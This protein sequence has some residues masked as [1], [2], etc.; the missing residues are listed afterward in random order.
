MNGF[1]LRRHGRA[2][3]QAEP[4]RTWFRCTRATVLED[5]EFTNNRIPVS[6]VYKQYISAATQSLASSNASDM[7]RAVETDK[8]RAD[9]AMRRAIKDFLD[10]PVVRAAFGEFKTK[11]DLPDFPVFLE[12]ELIHALQS[13]AETFHGLR[14]HPRVSWD[15]AVEAMDDQLKQ[16]V[17]EY[18]VRIEIWRCEGV[19]H[20][21]PWTFGTPSA[22]YHFLASTLVQLWYMDRE[23][24]FSFRSVRTS[25][26]DWDILWDSWA[27][28]G[29]TI[30]AADD[31]CVGVGRRRVGW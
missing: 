4:L 21:K 2:D 13:L 28:E 25:S 17:L 19:A 27:E 7:R 10:S 12:S 11:G 23:G 26:R 20:G 30:E 6:K 9:I 22:R 5:Y 3:A 15:N 16:T 8:H 1:R 14:L 24:C 29:M 31:G 18:L